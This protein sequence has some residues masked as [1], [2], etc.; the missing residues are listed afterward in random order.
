MALTAADLETLDAAIATGELTVEFN[1][2]RV[3]YRS[4]AELLAA[5]KH[6]ADVVAASTATAP[7]IGAYRVD[8]TTGRG[9]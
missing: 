7:R 8:F 3:T 2:R 6:V 5:R 9:F 1:G 4:V